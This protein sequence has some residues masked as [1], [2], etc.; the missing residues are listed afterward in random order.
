MIEAG[1]H[2]PSVTTHRPAAPPPTL[3]ITEFPIPTGKNI[4]GEITAGLDRNLWFTLD[5]HYGDLAC[6][7]QIGR[8]TPEGQITEFPIPTAISAPD[9]LPKSGPA[10]ITA[11][12]DGNLW[13]TDFNTAY[14]AL[15]GRITPEGQI[16]EFPLALSIYPEG[17]TSGPDDALWFT[18]GSAGIGRITPDGQITVFHPPLSNKAELSPFAITAG[19]DG[20]LWFTDCDSSGDQ[21]TTNLGRITPEG[22]VTEFP[23]TSPAGIPLGI[24]AGP[25]GNLWFTEPI[26]TIGRITPGGQITEFPLPTAGSG[27]HGIEPQGITI[28]PD[29]NLWFTEAGSNQI[30]RIVPDK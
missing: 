26:G 21:C 9:R 7:S 10:G 1:N 25:D 11:G 8:I 5:C 2:S 30:G 16:T 20:N 3:N 23:L 28:G 4:P 24:T 17:I 13:F 29:G 27:P 14:D 12:T 22:Q 15:I 6:V 19:P 18:A